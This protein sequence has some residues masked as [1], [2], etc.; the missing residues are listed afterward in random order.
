MRKSLLL[1]VP[2]LVLVGCS[3]NGLNPFGGNNVSGDMGGMATLAIQIIGPSKGTIEVDELNIVNANFRIIDAAAVTQTTNWNPPMS[4]Y[5]AFAPVAP[6]SAS[7]RLIDVDVTGRAA[8]NSLAYTF[9]GGYNYVIKVTLGGLVYMIETN[10]AAAAVSNHMAVYSETHIIPTGNSVFGP[11]NDANLFIWN[12]PTTLTEIG[13]NS[14][15]GASNWQI[16]R[17]ATNVANVWIGFGITSTNGVKNKTIYS[18]GHLKLAVKNSNPTNRY[19]VGVISV[20]G[21]VT[22][23]R[24]VSL[25]NV[26]GYAA[27]G[28]WKA[29]SIPFSDLP[30]DFTTVSCYFYFASENIVSNAVTVYLDDVYWSRD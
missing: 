18:T 28:T 7:L 1:L 14:W 21:G 2:F 25:T 9:R 24:F 12:S 6:G 23:D 3:I 19:K 13:A 26:P 20:T 15:E 16:T 5:I 11:G 27:D 17:V 22:N 29:L 10:P 8:T 4:G 30:I